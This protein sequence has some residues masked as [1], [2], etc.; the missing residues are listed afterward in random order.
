MA[1]TKIQI[2]HDKEV[3]ADLVHLLMTTKFT[4]KTHNVALQKTLNELLMGI[5]NGKIFTTIDDSSGGFASGTI[6]FSNFN[7]ANDTIVVNGVTLTAV[8]SGATGAQFN[9]G[10]SAAAQAANVS[11]LINSYSAFVGI[12]TSSVNG[13]VVTI[14]ALT[15][16]APGTAITL[17][18]GTDA[19]TVM[20]VAGL[21]NGRLTSAT[22]PTVLSSAS[23]TFGV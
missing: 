9:V 14:Q 5:R 12:L 15:L 11:A 6:T 18:K 21:T 13:A 3:A 23:Y 4:S 1:V 8:A 7:T 2:T 10:A 19:G 22:L 17:A 16:G 20:T